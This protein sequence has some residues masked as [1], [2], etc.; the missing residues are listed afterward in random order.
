MVVDVIGVVVVVVHVVVAVIPVVPYFNN[1]RGRMI[2]GKIKYNLPDARN[3][4]KSQWNK[5]VEKT[6]NLHNKNILLM[7]IKN[8]KKFDYLALEKEEFKPKL[9]LT[10][11]NLADE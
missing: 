8:Y 1:R 6:I 4:T 9:Y 3:H 5:I 10:T 7:K 11:L 2:K